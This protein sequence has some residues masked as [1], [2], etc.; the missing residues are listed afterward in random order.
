MLKT[1]RR[2]K[3]S[4]SALSCCIPEK[5]KR[6]PLK[7]NSGLPAGIGIGALWGWDQAEPH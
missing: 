6:H 3:W 2:L 4:S 7:V 1:P 5:R